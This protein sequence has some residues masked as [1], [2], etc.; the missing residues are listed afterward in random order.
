[1]T[2]FLLVILAIIMMMFTTTRANAVYWLKEDTATT[3][4]FG[5]FLDSTDG[6]TLETGLASALDNSTTGIRVAKNGSALSDRSSSTVPT[7]DSMGLYRVELDAT[8]TDTAGTLRIIF[9]E[10]ATC[11]PTWQDFVVIPSNSWD[12]IFGS[13]ALQ[14]DVIQIDGQIVSSTGAIAFPLGLTALAQGTAQSG[15]VATIQLA[16]AST[17]ADDVLNNNIIKITSGTGAGQSRRITDYTG[18]T[19]PLD[20]ATVSPSWTVSP[21]ETSVYEVVDASSN[22]E[23]AV[24]QVPVPRSRTFEIVRTSNGVVGDRNQGMLIGE[25]KTFAFDFARDL[26]TNGR[27]TS[28]DSIVIKT[29]SAGGVTFDTTNKAVDKTQSKI[30]ITGVTAGTYVLNVDVTYSDAFGGGTTSADCTLIVTP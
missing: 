8:D 18:S 5:P 26:P 29:G 11:L 24:S 30:K 1:M 25:S 6:V 17:F 19:A 2:R 21:D 27:L 22:A 10:S 13:D 9:E 23:I 20:T 28:F 14:V 15:T 4:Q 3:I 16:D 7:Y 12:S